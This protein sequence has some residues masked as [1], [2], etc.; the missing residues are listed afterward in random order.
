MDDKKVFMSVLITSFFGP[1]MASSV[2][3]AIPSMA[4]EYG[5]NAENLTWVLTLFLL[6]AVAFLLPCGKLADIKGRRKIYQLGC[7][8]VALST[9]FCIFTSDLKTLLLFRFIQGVCM[10]M[11]FSTG[12]AMLIASNPPQKRGQ[13]IGYSAA[14]VYLGLSLGPVIGG[15]LTEFLGWRTIFIFTAAGM[16]MSIY[17]MHFVKQ[18]WYGNQ[19]EKLDIPSSF[20]YALASTS[21]L[22]GL[23]DYVSHPLMKWLVVL[24]L[25]FGA[26]FIA[27]QK[28]TQYPLFTLNLFKNTIFAMSNLAA[29][30]HYSATFGISFVLS[31]Y[32]QIIRGLDPLNAGILLL[33]Q[34]I[35]MSI[36]SP[37]AGALSDKFEP[38]LVASSGMTLTAAG[39]FS[40]STIANNTSFYYIGSILLIIG[41]GFALFSSPNNNAIMGSVQ[42]EFYG[43]ASSILA[44]M[45][46]FG[47][48]TSM[49]IVS[50]LLSIYT[51]NI[52]PAEY[53][54]SLLSGMQQIFLVLAIT[55]TIGIF[56]S[57]ARGAKKNN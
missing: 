2:N 26:L 31:L 24:G 53:L 33:L 20:L 41:I 36:L 6:G 35:M 14:C 39:L 45:R 40:F 3:V 22:Y 13:I 30:I 19:K 18:E 16:S 23:S 27:R 25:V 51:T 15:A 17:I 11:N 52:I 34:P 1:F 12:M 28:Y 57:M 49:A 55:C 42:P 50:L 8:G 48:A 21:V 37:F 47:Q 44:A 54:T 32:L 7:I 9:L 5:V 46:M 4:L 10:S 43:V 29:L 38:R 56:C